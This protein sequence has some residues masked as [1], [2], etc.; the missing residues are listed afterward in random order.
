MKQEDK[1]DY[2]N[3]ARE[4]FGDTDCTID[5]DAKVAGA[6]LGAWVAAWVWVPMPEPEDTE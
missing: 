3:R 5:A 6:D 2:R 1:Q 4:M